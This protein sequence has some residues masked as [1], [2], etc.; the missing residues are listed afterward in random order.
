MADGPA[1]KP[2]YTPFYII[3]T[4]WILAIGVVLYLYFAQNP[5][6]YG[7]NDQSATT[8]SRQQPIPGVFAISSPAFADGGSIP[9]QYT[10]DEKQMSPPLRFTGVPEGTKSLALVMEDRDI[11]KN[12]K[13]DGTFLHWIVYD[14][15]PHTTDVTAG[16][17]FGTEGVNGLG[18]E[19]YMGPCAPKNVEP[20]E[21]RYY[22][23]LYALDIALAKDSGLN[24]EQLTEAMDGHIL[25]QTEFM[26]RYERK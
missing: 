6:I 9:S 2:S 13:A 11:P 21:H 12:L 23:T 4:L 10:C 24:K 20:T 19:G 25:A 14:I 17:V 7:V 8:T 18:V 22:F 1:P 26:G 5:E 3:G 16:G 15:E